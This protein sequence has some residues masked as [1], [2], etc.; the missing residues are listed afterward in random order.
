[1]PKY[2]SSAQIRAGRGL[3]GWSRSELAKNAKVALNTVTLMENKLNAKNQ[4]TREKVQRVMEAAGVAFFDGDEVGG[5]GVRFI[6]VAHQ[7]KV[8][9]VDAEP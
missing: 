9:D 2:P 3:L 8:G 4:T 6:S 1:M 5:E 7:P